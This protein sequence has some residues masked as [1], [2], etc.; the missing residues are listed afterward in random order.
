MKNIG[1]ETFREVKELSWDKIKR[2]RKVASFRNKYFMMMTAC[3]YFL[4]ET[5]S[6]IQLGGQIQDCFCLFVFLLFLGKK[7]LEH[8]MNY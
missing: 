5:Y 7:I 2:R 3:H 1:S 4:S 6:C 8:K